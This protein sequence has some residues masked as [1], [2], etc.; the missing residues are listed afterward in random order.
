M[1]RGLACL[2]AWLLCAAC[3]SA[4]AQSP[5]APAPAPPR[6][7]VEALAHF[8]V[9]TAPFDVPALRHA[10]GQ[11]F[12]LLG[13]A[14]C[15]LSPLWGLELRVPLL[16]GSVAQPAGAYVDAAALGNLQLGVRRLL[17]QRS[18]GTSS[19]TLAA[20]FEIGA[21]LASSDHDLLQNRLLAVGDGIEGHGY[22]ELFTPGTLPLT[23]S[24]SLLYTVE[25]WTLAAEL[26]VPVFVRLSDADLPSSLSSRT[27][28]LGITSVAR[29]EARYRLSSRFSAA[30]STHLAVD[31]APVAERLPGVSRVQDFE[32]LSLLIHLGQRA[33]LAVD[34][35]TAIFGELGGNTF[36]GGLRL[37][38]D[39]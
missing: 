33:A 20:L 28:T 24:A 14:R 35:Q 30:A 16:L 19:L 27:K 13:T 34:L 2:L 12:V 5:E 32:R 9:A 23:P 17:T 11:A 18:F 22:P 15:P 38:V 31:L 29:V 3:P 36:G 37:G 21:P 7:R 6:A 1:K 25:R 4:A 10:K 39:F 26:R 8:G